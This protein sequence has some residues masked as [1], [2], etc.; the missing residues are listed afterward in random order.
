MVLATGVV[1]RKLKLPGADHKKV[2]SYVD[3]LRH[4][5]QVWM[6]LGRHR[7]VCVLLP[8][9]ETLLLSVSSPPRTSPTTD[10]TFRPFFSHSGTS[11]TIF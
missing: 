1:P 3:V 4:N 8:E 9:S 11:L 6:M 5:V 10:A 7:L 2:V